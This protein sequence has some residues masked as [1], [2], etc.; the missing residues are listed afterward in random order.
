[1]STFS[2]LQWTTWRQSCI[3]Y[4]QTYRVNQLWWATCGASSKHHFVGR[5]CWSH[6]ANVDALHLMLDFDY[7]VVDDKHS[8]AI[9][10]TILIKKSGNL[11]SI[12]LDWRWIYHTSAIWTQ[13]YPQFN[14]DN[15]HSTS[16]IELYGHM[17]INNK[18]WTLTWFP[19]GR[20]NY[21]NV[22]KIKMWF[23]MLK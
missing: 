18:T 23:N 12:H 4:I 14:M 3:H 20:V 7:D 6:Q 19:I 21:V 17:G 5:S 9:Q 16:V 22:K 11:I 13:N 2:Y 1:M 8:T 10:F 15:N